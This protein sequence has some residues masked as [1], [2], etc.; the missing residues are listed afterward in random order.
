MA[1]AKTDQQ[2]ERVHDDALAEHV[3]WL[4]RYAG[5]H[6]SARM[7]QAL[8]LAHRRGVAEPGAADGSVE[9]Q[10]GGA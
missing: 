9:P 5:D 10:G 7:L 6:D 4:F 3:A 1:D 2:S 8:V